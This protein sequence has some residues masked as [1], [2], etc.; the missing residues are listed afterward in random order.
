LPQLQ[1]GPQLPDRVASA[2]TGVS[3]LREELWKLEGQARG[4]AEE[5]LVT[6][7]DKLVAAERLLAQTGADKAEFEGADAEAKWMAGALRDF[8]RVWG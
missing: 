7:T 6:E 2:S 4:S 3:R 1:E 8:G 5:K